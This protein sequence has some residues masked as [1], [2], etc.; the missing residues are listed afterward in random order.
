MAYRCKQVTVVAYAHT[1]S[2]NTKLDLYTTSWKSRHVLSSMS[3]F[4][5]AELNKTPETL[6]LQI[7]FYF[8]RVDFAFGS[9]QRTTSLS[10][11]LNFFFATNLLYSYF[12]KC[13]YFLIVLNTELNGCGR[14]RY[15]EG[16]I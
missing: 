16:I 13:A 1:H 8:C 10:T 15:G 5:N 12:I 9:T 4:T 7:N 14:R 11:Q 6:M 3:M 2:S